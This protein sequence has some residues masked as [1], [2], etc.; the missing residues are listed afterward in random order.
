MRIAQVAP[1]HESCP[2]RFYG[3]TERVVSYLTEELVGLG[4]EV[5]LFASGDSRTAAT[6]EA[7]CEIALRLDR[8]CKDPLVYHLIM[9]EPCGAAPTSS[10]SSISTPTTCIFRCSPIAWGKT[11][12]DAARPARSARSSG[13][14]ARIPDDAAGIDLGRAAGADA[15]GQLVRHGA[16]RPAAR[17]STRSARA[18]R[19]PRVSRPHQPGKGLGPGHRNCPPRAA[20]AADRGQGRPGRSALLRDQ[21]RRVAERS[22]RSSSSARSARPTREHFSGMRGAAVSDRLAGAVRPGP[23]RGDGERHAGHR[24]SAAAPS[25][26]SSRMA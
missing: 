2:P 4:H 22:G 1:L 21:D 24:L 11:L 18:G 10:T 14:D 7:G 12:D 6:L 20:A 15:V 17:T 13:H 5:T 16:A 3:G 9:L 25:P 23:D 19:L 26:R 8:R